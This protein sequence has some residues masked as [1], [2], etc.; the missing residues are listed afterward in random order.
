MSIFEPKLSEIDPVAAR[1]N[2]AVN[3][4]WFVRTFGALALG[5]SVASMASIGFLIGAGM[6]VM[7]F[8]TSRFYRWLGLAII[9]LSGT[10]M[11]LPP[12]LQ[13]LG[14]CASVLALGGGVCVKGFKILELL[15]GSDQSDPDWKPTQRKALVGMLLSGLGVILVLG[16]VTLSVTGY[17]FFPKPNQRSQQQVGTVGLK[18]FQLG[19]AALHIDLPGQPSLQTDLVQENVKNQIDHNQIYQWNQDGILVHIESVVFHTGIQPDIQAIASAANQN[20]RSTNEKDA[21]PQIQAS[22]DPTNPS[23]LFL[24]G[25]MMLNGKN[26]ELVGVVLNRNENVAVV[27]ALYDPQNQSSYRLAQQVLDSAS[28]GS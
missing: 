27:V 14:H 23:R 3:D 17:L 1:F 15:G 28:L 10:G 8:G 11:F 4:A 25:T 12:G 20:L 6:A 21:P 2:E 24:T 16:W 18:R 19:K 7:G 26:L 22:N 9:L 5:A 13:S